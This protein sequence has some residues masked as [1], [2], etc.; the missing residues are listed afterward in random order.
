MYTLREIVRAFYR[1][2]LN[3]ESSKIKFAFNLSYYCNLSDFKSKK[4]K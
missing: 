4:V 1:L 2:N 3:S